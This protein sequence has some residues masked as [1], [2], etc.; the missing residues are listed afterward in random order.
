MLQQKN[1]KSETKYHIHIREMGMIESWHTSSLWHRIHV[2]QHAGSC[3]RCHSS[4]W[5]RYVVQQQHKISLYYSNKPKHKLVTSIFVSQCKLKSD[6]TV[7]ICL[8]QPGPVIATV[9]FNRLWKS[10]WLQGRAGVSNTRPAGRMPVGHMRPSKQFYA[11]HNNLPK[12]PKFCEFH[13]IGPQFSLFSTQFTV[14][15]ESVPVELQ[16]EVVDLQCDSSLFLSRST[17]RLA[18]LISTSF[19]QE[20]IFRNSWWMQLQESCPCLAV[21]TFVSSSSRQWSWTNQLYGQDLQMN[22][23]V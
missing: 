20:H 15:A 3:M 17:R 9:T 23:F 6:R 16:M 18:F 11:A 12:M 8:S 19:Y 5:L 1:S 21:H 13:A 14:D 7:C 4:D 22:I 10:Y 2:L